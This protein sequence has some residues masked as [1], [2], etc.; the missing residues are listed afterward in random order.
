VN[1]C[2]PLAGGGGRCVEGCRGRARVRRRG[3]QRVCGR[4]V[5]VD[6]IT[7]KLKPPGT[8][9]SKLNCDELLSSFAFKFDLRRFIADACARAGDYP[10]AAQAV[11][12]MRRQAGG[13]F[14]TS[15]RPTLN[16]GG[17]FFL[18]LGHSNWS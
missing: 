1:E 15:T 5:H 10:R 12:W 6:P 9:R 18:N 7:P 17:M 3:L 11:D 16:R 13:L 8:K 2:K 14:R 4:A